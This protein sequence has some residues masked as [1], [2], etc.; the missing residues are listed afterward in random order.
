MLF[1]GDVKVLEFT[2]DCAREFG[3]I[4]GDSLLKG[5][6]FN[7]MDLLIAASAIVHDLTLVT[8]NTQDFRN[9]PNLHLEDWVI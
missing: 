7:K 2:T 1:D 8:H 4:R 3:R 5:I 6:C 9:I